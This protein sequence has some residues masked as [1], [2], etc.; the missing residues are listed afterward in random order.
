ME[1]RHTPILALSTDAITNWTRLVTD[2]PGSIVES[3][4]TPDGLY[5]EVRDTGRLTEVFEFSET[6]ILFLLSGKSESGKSHWGK[7]FVEQKYGSRVKILKLVH[8]QWPEEDPNDVLSSITT[9]EDP[10]IHTL[11]ESFANLLQKQQTPL[12]VVETLKHPEIVSFLTASNHIRAVS[13]FLEP[14]FDLR[15]QREALS[16]DIP[17]EEATALAIQK[18]QQKAVLGNERIRDIADIYIQNNGDIATYNAFIDK[19][20]YIGRM[21]TPQMEGTPITYA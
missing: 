11:A 14:D 8:D 2:T 10:R 15:V 18:D 5:M 9:P 3:I 20:A 4:K 12:A 7:R 16:K 13:V 21:A 17:V 6:P 19:I 1:Q